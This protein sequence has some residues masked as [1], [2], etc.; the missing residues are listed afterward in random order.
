MCDPAQEVRETCE[1]ALE[2]IEQMKD[3]GDGS[4][5]EKSPFMSVDPAAPTTSCSSVHQLRF[6]WLLELFGPFF[7]YYICYAF[8]LCQ[9]ILREVLLD[10]E[11][12][13]YERYAALFAL[14]NNGGKE[15]V[16]AIVDSLGS[17]SALLKHEVR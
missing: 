13:M 14:R 16:E 10:E 12:G 7:S 8:D 1:L 11:K 4:T 3:A 9:F 15:A 2:R 6:V 5:A 17:N